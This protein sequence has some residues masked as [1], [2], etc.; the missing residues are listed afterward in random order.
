MLTE[1]ETG[2]TILETSELAGAALLT[3]VSDRLE[4]LLAGRR[5][6]TSPISTE[7]EV[8][9]SSGYAIIG[10]DRL[11]PLDPEHTLRIQ[12]RLCT[13]GQA[14][15]A[16]IRSRF[17]SAED[18]A[19]ADLTAG[20][21]P[22]L[23][24]MVDNYHCE[25]GTSHYRYRFGKE[26]FLVGDVPTARQVMSFINNPDRKVPVLAITEDST[27]RTA[28]EPQDALDY[29]LGLA[30][31]VRFAGGTSSHI[32]EAT[33]KACYNGAMRFYW[34]GG[35]VS[36][37][38]WPDEAATISITQ[39]QRDCIENAEIHDLNGDFE[40]T[41]SSVRTRVIREQRDEPTTLLSNRGTGTVEAENQ[42]S[43]LQ[44]QHEISLEREAHRQTTDQLRQANEEL[45]TLRREKSESDKKHEQTINDLLE[46]LNITEAP[47][48]TASDSEKDRKLR[49][50]NTEI[51]QWKRRLTQYQDGNRELMKENRELKESLERAEADAAAASIPVIT[52]TARGDELQL[53]GNA[54][55]DNITILNHAINIYRNPVRQ[56]IIKA[57]RKRYSN[58][59]SELCEV[60][61]RTM[62]SDDDRKRLYESKANKRLQD[63]IDVKHFEH[64]V[65][66]N[67]TCFG[68]KPRLSTKM[69]D[70]RQVRNAAA[71]PEY[72]GIDNLKARDGLNKIADALRE[73]GNNDY[74]KLVEQLLLFVR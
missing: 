47:S 46:R 13:E 36:K 20:P 67:R 5:R 19:P 27:G 24:E 63:G 31:V 52:E 16:Q 37:F 29:L 2:F 25:I 18:S 43:L 38:Y 57:L 50:Q 48:S 34:P 14:V 23:R 15:T 64:I 9:A 68:E 71:H 7:R 61:E 6:D 11:H 10:A 56:Y 33:G 54:R 42:I 8:S 51:N 73:T 74:G 72:N 17:I 66:D 58:D 44:L 35:S 12:A 39:F 1:Y 70:V 55:I 28:I 45:D 40:Q 65:M 41:F 4:S 22:S 32:R 69:S 59:L 21:P 60:I 30:L 53:T 62:N 3:D 26:V 49:L